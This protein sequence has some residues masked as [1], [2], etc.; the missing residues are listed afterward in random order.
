LGPQIANPHIAKKYSPKIANLP[1][2]PFVEMPQIYKKKIKSC[3]YSPFAK[4]NA[5]RPPLIIED[6]A[7]ETV[8]RGG[9]KTHTSTY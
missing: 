1:M 8:L 9:F 4:L 6:Q 2:A 3:P 5:D 7:K